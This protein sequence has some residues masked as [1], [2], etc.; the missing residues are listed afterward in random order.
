MAADLLAIASYG[1]IILHCH[2]LV[3]FHIAINAK[4]VGVPGCVGGK[5]LEALVW[6]TSALSQRGGV[7]A[8][9]KSIFWK[10]SSN[11]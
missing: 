5:Y 9:A 7:P 4:E 2:Y 10:R 3:G 6:L 1:S 8:A 11:R